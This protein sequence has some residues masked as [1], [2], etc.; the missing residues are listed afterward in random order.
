LNRYIQ[1]QSPSGT[2]EL[3]DQAMG[4]MLFPI[5][6]VLDPRQQPRRGLRGAIGGRDQRSKLGVADVGQRGLD[7]GQVGVHGDI[8]RCAV[9]L[10]F[11]RPTLS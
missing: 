8:L 1:Q 2:P 11:L 10:C 7:G 3:Q 9:G 4:S 6:S 5:G